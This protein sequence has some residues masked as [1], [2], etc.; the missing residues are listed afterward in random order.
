MYENFSALSTESL[1]SIFNRLQKI[2]VTRNLSDATVYA[3]LANQPNG[4]QLV[5][6]DLGQIHED[7]LEEM[8]LKWQLALLSMRTRNFFRKTGRKITINDDTS[9][10]GIIKGKKQDNSRRTINGGRNSLP[11]PCWLLMELVLTGALWQMKKSLSKY[12]SYGFLDSEDLE[13][14]V[15][16]SELEKLKQ[17]KERNQLKI[18]KFDNASKSLDKLTRSRIPDKS[19]KGLGFVSYNAIPPPPTGLFS[20]PNIDLSNSGLEEFQM[21]ELKDRT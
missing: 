16:K 15:L 18:G 19:R 11:K 21:P 3:F 17:A 10:I 1:D 8:D 9:G 7:D 6:N 2:L 5:H 20:P 13:I 14:S 12:G 4:S